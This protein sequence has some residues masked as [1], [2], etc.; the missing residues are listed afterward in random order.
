MN[1]D[2]IFLVFFSFTFFIPDFGSIDLIAPKAFYLSIISF[3]FLLF[4][5]SF[6]IDVFDNT[7]FIFTLYILLFIISL[8]SS[9]YA[10]NIPEVFIFSFRL[11][12][13]I[14]ALISLYII[15]NR[16]NSLIIFP[17]FLQMILFVE[18]LFL[19]NDFNNLSDNF[20]FS[21]R[22][23][24]SGSSSN[25]NISSFSLL[26]KIPFSILLY[27]FTKSKI[28]K[29][30]SLFTIAASIFFII[31]QGSRAAFV[32]ILIYLLSYLILF[33]IQRKF[34][35]Q[36]LSLITVSVTTFYITNNAVIN[37]VSSVDIVSD[38]STSY[39]LNLYNGVLN[40]FVENPLFGTGA[41]NYKISS[42]FYNN[43]NIQSYIM[44]YHAHNDFLEYLSDLGII[45]F[46][47]YLSIFIFLFSYIVRIIL[48]SDKS[49]QLVGFTCMLS[50]IA[51]FF[52]SL[53]NFP[54]SRVIQQL[55]FMSLTSFVLIIH[56]NYVSK[57]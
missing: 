22:F 57:K 39:R 25:I 56:N 10:I 15:F 36:L 26:F 11:F 37:R 42:I 16:N 44:P 5:R 38:S 24:G 14:C 32:V 31:I 13:Y 30:L 48:L 51:Y 18:V 55:F 1:R 54:S 34:L 2:Y 4:N 43:L 7:S 33:T 21:T 47:I 3:I 50:F 12:V 17:F 9:I 8:F 41:G 20:N 45:G 28:L 46:L 23:M 52:D 27:E 29:A 19:L 6:I 53:F 49:I 40:S 35:I